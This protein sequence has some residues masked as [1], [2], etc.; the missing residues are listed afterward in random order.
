MRIPDLTRNA[1]QARHAPMG[2]DV[3]AMDGMRV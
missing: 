1:K 2:G 3:D